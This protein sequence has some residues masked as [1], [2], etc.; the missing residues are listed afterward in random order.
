M[1]TLAALRNHLDMLSCEIGPRPVGSVGNQRAETYIAQQLEKDGFTVRHQKFECEDWQ[2]QEV[3]VE[4]DGLHMPVRPNSYSAACD[5]RAPLLTAQTIE[6]LKAL[7]MRGRVVALHGGLSA[8]PWQ[9][10]HLRYFSFRDQQRLREQ[11]ERAQPAAVITI[12]PR[13]EH[14]RPIIEDGEFRIP[15]VT[16]NSSA[17]ARLIAAEGHIVR[18][19]VDSRTRASLG[20]NVI[21]D[22]PV[23]PRGSV[24]QVLLCA[25][26]DTKHGSPGA[27]DNASGVAAMLVLAARLRARRDLEVHCVGLNGHDHFASPGQQVYQAFLGDAQTSLDLVINFDDIGYQA[28]SNTVAFMSCTDRF[29]QRVRE[30]IARYPGIFEIGPW[31]QGDHAMFWAAGVPSVAFTSEASFA[32]PDRVTHTPFDVVDNV[33]AESICDVVNFVED[34]LLDDL[35]TLPARRV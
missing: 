17:G 28:A 13:N 22:A 2:L 27:L 8:D 15:S 12:S 25:H 5:V 29:V 34:A 9:P 30:R 35:A 16:V 18:V 3:D 7:E 31:P 24:P 10:R 33:N 1:Q 32:L 19:R 14:V 21:A 20:A 26:Y 4:V 23:R 6:D 11:L